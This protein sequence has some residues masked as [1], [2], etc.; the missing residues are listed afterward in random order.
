MQKDAIL[1]AA[2]K[3]TSDLYAW[4]TRA[5]NV[6]MTVVAFAGLPVVMLTIV[7]ATR[8]PEQWQAALIFVAL[9]AFLVTLVIFRRVNFYLR[10]WIL[11]LTGYVAGTYAF[12][13][14]GL[15]GDGRIF[16]LALPM[17]A[18]I[19][20]GS[21][22]GLVAAALS[23]L[24]FVALGAT[25]HIG[26]MGERWLVTPENPLELTSWLAGG[27]AFFMLLMGLMV[28]QWQL[29][30]FL[31]RLAAEK[32]R[33]H[34]ESERL[35]IFNE[36]IVQ[37][38]DE[39]V[40]IEDTAGIITFI[41]PKAEELLDSAP[42]D[43]IGQHWNAFVPPE[44]MAQ[45]QE[46]SEK[47]A[48]GAASLYEAALLTRKGKRVPVIVSARPLFDG[49]RF[50][51]VLTVLTDV[52]E[53]RRAEEML[54]HRNRELALLHRAIQAFSS[55]LDSN[56]VLA[57]VLDEVRHLLHVVACSAWLI[58][59]DT[60]ELICRQAA[61][62]GNELMRGY[63]L[64][65]GVGLAG[66]AVR[67]G[68]SLVVSD[69]QAD[70]RY[71]EDVARKT[72]LELRS[73]LTIPLQVKQDVIGVLQVV[74]TEVGRF[75]KNDLALLEPLAA[76]A[77]IAIENARLYERAQQEITERRQAEESLRES[78]EK[79]RNLVERANDGIAIV[80]DTIVKYANP[81]LAE[82]WGSADEII[83]GVPFTDYVHP[84]EL[85]KL[86]DLYKRRVAGEDVESVY[87]T[88]LKRK[89][90]NKV[91]VELSAGI[92]PYEGRPADLMIVRDITQRKQ[93]EKAL[94]QYIERLRTLYAI[95][96]A[97]LAAW[98]AEEIAQV[99]LRHMRELVPCLQASVVTFEREGQEATVFA[100]QT[101]GETTLSPG[102]RYSPDDSTI[103]KL[104][105]GEVHVVE[106]TLAISKPSQAVQSLQVEGLRSYIT[107]PLLVRGKLIGCIN[108][109]ADSP[110][111]FTPEHINIIREISDQIAVA[112]HQA[113]LHSALEAEQQRLT[114]LVG[115]L[116]EGVLLL[117]DER[118]ILLA[119]PTAQA[120]LLVLADA[121][122]PS[123][124]CVGDVLTRLADRSI[125]ELLQPPPAG[126]WHEL[127]IAGPPVRSFEVV[128]QPIAAETG[129][130]GWVLLIRDVTEER[131]VQRWIQQ[132]ERLAAVGQ[133]A[134]GIAHDFNNLLTAIMLHAQI[135]LRKRDLPP[136]L[137][138]ALKTI[139]GQ[140]RRAAELVQQILDF[141]RRAPIETRLLDLKP[142]VKETMRVLERTIPEN[143][144]LIQ[145]M[146]RGKYVV[147]ADP[148]RI[149]QVLM[150][151][152]VNAR[153]AM[154]E[155][156]DLCV[157]LT[158]VEVGPEKEPPA[159]GTPPITTPPHPSTTDTLGTEGKEWVCLVV[160]DTGTGIPPDALPH[161]FEPFFTTKEPG[162]GTGLG[163]AQV[164][165]IVAQHG[166]HIRV[167]TEVR[168]GTIFRIYLP[169][170]MEEA[171]EITEK[172][173]ILPEGRGETILLVEDE[174]KLREVGQ[175]ILE[176][177]G[178]R[179]LAAVNGQ[180]ALEVYR[181]A[182][183]VDLVVTD[184]MMP[185]MGGRELMRELRKTAPHLK[186]II[187]T[188][189]ALA[190]DMEA[191]SEEGIVEAVSK[192]FDIGT[193]ANAVRRALDAEENG[194]AK[195]S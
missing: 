29:N 93:T 69:A 78:E 141:S 94:R 117:D 101:N 146:G 33:L 13:R 100:A 7:L 136:D 49:D 44:R 153:D 192:P 40:I 125:A 156:G 67:H 172:D 65:P 184:V 26:W 138:R 28:M 148:T 11:L 175:E 68:E 8:D 25:A 20:A 105:R 22:S 79:Y 144:H 95:D 58:D 155:G 51:G 71:S 128:A 171:E 2:F 132:Q 103:R 97:I 24:I 89:D 189:Y 151:L 147:D 123:A 41:N 18:L 180:E 167:E 12:A 64:A 9:Y 32:G 50:T 88:V 31:T 73:I 57:T 190:E 169:A 130:G 87:E 140:S 124:T 137:A 109:G 61:G 163:L 166:G 62:P 145:R 131:E 30:R 129:A 193:L 85:P 157:E 122:G 60:D 52:T 17:L 84:D 115:H 55:T 133:L 185:G 159:A 6:M 83:T 70:D 107:M 149:Q 139:L 161:I 15:A 14:G 186:G 80:Q 27:A 21:R 112:L 42:E 45:V 10:A 119:N 143:I 168:K 99:A 36:N 121:A 126:L 47:R 48:Q 135:P 63:H 86:M 181:S 142:F 81:R 179:V 120:H 1:N 118:R 113:R 195:Q 34:E 91:Y 75:D 108:L 191:L 106:D 3:G 96:G 183:T 162:K 182:E 116:P 4:R 59:P 5:L 16:L 35:R 19:I 164:H 174:E 82:M 178:Y 102:T 152:V 38:M 165:G 114:T 43:L 111:A 66:W 177:L 134:G 37:S 74:D 72:S 158:R 53:L 54:R 98:S 39:G 150:N 46:E 194:N 110:N 154:P 77:A 90:G 160:S 56:Q 76:S 176:S 104:W 188:G 23:L 173:R 127:E 170:Q 92:V 187:I